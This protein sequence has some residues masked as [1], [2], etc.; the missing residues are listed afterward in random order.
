MKIMHEHMQWKDRGTHGRVLNWR[1][2]DPKP[3][4]EKKRVVGLM[5]AGKKSVLKGEGIE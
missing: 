3:K 1:I 2:E 4:L 5:F